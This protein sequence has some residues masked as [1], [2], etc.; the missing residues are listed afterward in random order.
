[1]QASR[2]ITT[3]NSVA[4]E[5]RVAE[6]TEATTKLCGEKLEEA[7]WQT[8]ESK[9]VVMAREASTVVSTKAP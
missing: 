8:L 6:A 7:H 3:G 2:I 5:N 1:M 9:D 4:V